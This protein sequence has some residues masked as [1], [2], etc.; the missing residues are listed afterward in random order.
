M[1]RRAGYRGWDFPAILVDFMEDVPD[2]YAQP[3]DPRRALA[4]FNETAKALHEHYWLRTP[5]AWGTFVLF[6]LS[7]PLQG[8]R[9]V[10]VRDRRT[11][12]DCAQVRKDLAE[13]HFPEA[14][15][16]VLV[17]D[18]LNTHTPRFLNKAFDQATADRLAARFAWYYTPPHGI[19]FHMAEI[20]LSQL[21][22]PCLRRRM[23]TVEFMAEEVVAW[24]QD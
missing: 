15:K 5:A 7:A 24:C 18:N 20:A 9:T 13:V 22:R 4:C 11:A 3:V 19:W 12:V 10:D 2:V 14:E 6:L 8:W 23:V 1:G 21:P 17:W 16:I